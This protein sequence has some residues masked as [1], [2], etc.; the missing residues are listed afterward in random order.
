MCPS[1]PGVSTI[2][3]LI[4]YARDRRLRDR[5][6]PPFPATKFWGISKQRGVAHVNRAVN[7]VEHRGG[8]KFKERGGSVGSTEGGTTVAPD[9]NAQRAT[10]Q[11]RTTH[12]RGGLSLFCLFR[13]R[14]FTK[15]DFVLRNFLTLPRVGPVDCA[16]CLLPCLPPSLFL[17]SPVTSPS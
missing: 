15:V 6:S 3:R 5:D 8:L 1:S 12:L 17:Y 2:L 9:I 16:T 7:Q 10:V 14:I 13:T 11:M 4:Y